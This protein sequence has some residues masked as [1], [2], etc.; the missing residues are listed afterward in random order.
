MQKLIR[1]SAAFLLL[2]IVG[3]GFYISGSPTQNRKIAKDLE[4]LDELDQVHCLLQRRY[5]R[6]QSV[7]TDL[8]ADELNKY[9]AYDYRPGQTCEI[10]YCNTAVELQPSINDRYR[11]T[12]SAHGY[13]ICAQF[14]SSFDDIRKNR[15]SYSYYGYNWDWASKIMPG[16][17]CFERTFEECK[18]ETK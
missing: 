16:E 12:S 14:S 1:Y 9:R 8:R 6:D 5:T 11:Y 2:G 18:K 7:P 10:R 13:K 17:N 4:T 15:S 3:Y